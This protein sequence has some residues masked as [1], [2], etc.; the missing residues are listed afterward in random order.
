MCLLLRKWTSRLKTSQFLPLPWRRPLVK[1]AMAAIQE[2]V[3]ILAT[4]A[5]ADE[6]VRGERD[7][8]T[9]SSNRLSRIYCAKDRKYSFKSQKSQSLKRGRASLRTLHCPAGF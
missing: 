2:A 3:V 1:R 9:D 8:E 5:E 4:V 6:A 7:A